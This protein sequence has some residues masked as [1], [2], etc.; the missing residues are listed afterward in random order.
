[1]IN[2]NLCIVNSKTLYEILF[3]LKNYFPYEIIFIKSENLN[4]DNF[5]SNNTIYL[6]N[7]VEPELISK[8]KFNQILEIKNLPLK[9]RDLIVKINIQFLKVNFHN[10]A[11]IKIK[12]YNLDINSK[13]ISKK[14]TQLKLTE[15]E[16]QIILYLF[17]N[18]K[19]KTVQDLQKNIWNHQNDLETHTV[20]THIYR[21]RK[22]IRENFNDEDFIIN[23]DFGY[24]L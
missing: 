7:K 13:L 9:I 15:K 20:E 11:N 14:N 16:I 17:S 10:Q 24:K 2:K 5:I 18:Y 23:S 8:F 4:K 3:E 21:L 22:K 1:M 19:S 6:I 12:D